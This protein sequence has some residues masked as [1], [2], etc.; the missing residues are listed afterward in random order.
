MIH[1]EERRPPVV[2]EI[3]D[4][5]DGHRAPPVRVPR[6]LTGIEDDGLDLAEAAVHQPEAEGQVEDKQDV[7]VRSQLHPGGEASKLALVQPLTLI[8]LLHPVVPRREAGDRRCRV[9]PPLLAH[10]PPQAADIVEVAVIL[11]PRLG[12]STVVHDDWCVREASPLGEGELR[13]LALAEPEVV[14]HRPGQ[15]PQTP[16]GA[17][18]A[19]GPVVVRLLRLRL[20]GLHRLQPVTAGEHHDLRA[21]PVDFQTAVRELRRPGPFRRC[22]VR[23]RVVDLLVVKG[24]ALRGVAHPYEG[25]TAQ[26]FVQVRFPCLALRE[27]AVRPPRELSAE[28]AHLADKDEAR[29]PQVFLELQQCIPSGV[30]LAEEGWGKPVDQAVHRRGGEADIEGGRSSRGRHAHEAGRESCPL[31]L[32]EDLLQGR[33]RGACLARTGFPKQEQAEGF[34]L[35]GRSRVDAPDQVSHVLEK[36]MHEQLLIVVTELISPQA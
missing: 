28:H 3:D 22:F 26:A 4:D 29:I 27:P 33:L 20:R 35:A 13:P 7:G 31:K 23:H 1:V 15:V 24:L 14:L 34:G 6:A 32:H 16:Q 5:R 36:D 11:R 21:G 12:R 9:L 25:Q 18:P 30:Q 19:H 2:W 17:H 8:L 10:H